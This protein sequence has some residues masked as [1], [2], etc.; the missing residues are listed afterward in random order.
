MGLNRRKFLQMSALASIA[1]PALFAENQ[2][3]QK[4]SDASFKRAYPNSVK[5]RTICTHCSVGCGIEAEVVNGVWVRQEPAFEHPISTGGHCCKGADMIDKARSETRLRYP[6][7]KING[8]WVRTKYKDALDQI[9]D[10]ITAIKNQYGPD[11]IMFIGSAKFSNEQCYYLRKF[12][13]FMGTN[14]IDHQARI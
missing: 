11:S 8:T 9:C 3:I 12:A 14:N 5:K 6:M 4:E 13:A 2:T 7:Q 1:T 10:K